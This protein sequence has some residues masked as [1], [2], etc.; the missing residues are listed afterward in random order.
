MV[1]SNLDAYKIKEQPNPMSPEPPTASKYMSG[2]FK[3]TSSSFKNLKIG[4][5]F[6]PKSLN[7]ASK[8]SSA[9]TASL[10]ALTPTPE[11]IEKLKSSTNSNFSYLKNA[12]SS[13]LQ[14]FAEDVKLE[15]ETIKEVFSPIDNQMFP[16]EDLL[17]KHK[18]TKS[19]P[20]LHIQSKVDGIK[21]L[22]ATSEDDY[23]YLFHLGYKGN[24]QYGRVLEK[25]KLIDLIKITSRKK[26]P[27]ILTFKFGDPEKFQDNQFIEKIQ[28]KDETEIFD[29][30]LR[31]HMPDIAA[32]AAREIKGRIVEAIAKMDK[33]DKIE[34]NISEV[35]T[36]EKNVKDSES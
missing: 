33:S 26:N 35:N 18:I 2:L 6:K 9:T 32:D 16:I 27:E 34:E 7:F 25:R 17:E 11:S 29:C 24:N 15:I 23:I 31:L 8:L 21:S 20:A 36:S 14:T 10:S 19:Y 22:V 1:G 4:Q 30:I 13:G 5:N 3:S 28:N 12:M